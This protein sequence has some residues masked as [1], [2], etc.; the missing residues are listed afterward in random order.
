VIAIVVV[1]RRN[2]IGM[3]RRSVDGDI[4][5]NDTGTNPP[6]DVASTGRA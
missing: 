5:G 4:A 6:V 2:W 3:S 1:P